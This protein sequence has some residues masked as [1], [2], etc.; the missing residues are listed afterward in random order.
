[1]TLSCTNPWS[2]NHYGNGI[3]INKVTVANVEDISGQQ[4]PFLDTPFDIGI[5]FVLD[6]GRDFQPELI[7]AGNF[8]RDPITDEVIGWG[9][10]FVVQEALAKLGY[11]GNLEDGNKIP[12]EILKEFIGESFYRLAYVSGLKGNGKPKYTDWNQIA[13]LEEGADS[14]MKRFKKSLQKG[15]PKNYRPSLLDETPPVEE[16]V[17]VTGDEDPF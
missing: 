17:T 15:Y 8:K 4:S 10:G 1:M 16:A 6:I 7:I 5:K 9:N 11:T 3:F 12:P 2:A 14:L 13:T